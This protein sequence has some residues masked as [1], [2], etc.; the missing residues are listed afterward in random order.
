MKIMSLAIAS[1]VDANL[2]QDY[3]RQF[4]GSSSSNIEEQFR[5]GRQ[6]RSRSI[7]DLIGLAIGWFGQ[8]AD[9]AR[10]RAEERRATEKLL[11]LSDHLQKDMGLAENDL[12]GLRLGHLSLSDIGQRRKSLQSTV[13]PNLL[14]QGRPVAKNILELD[15]A[16]QDSFELAK[17][18]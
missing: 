6:I 8:I 3:T 9:K 13:Q 5:Y 11:N 17:C 2:N 10:Q 1:I 4:T 12:Q 18:S 16:N 14:A 15:S 7:F